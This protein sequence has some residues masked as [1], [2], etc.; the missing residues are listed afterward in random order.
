MVSNTTQ[1]PPPPNQTLIQCRWTLP[2]LN[3][4]GPKLMVWPP[5]PSFMVSASHRKIS[6]F[7]MTTFVNKNK[8]NFSSFSQVLSAE[9]RIIWNV[10]MDTDLS[11]SPT[12][13]KQTKKGTP[14]L[15]EFWISV[16]LCIRE[17]VT[18]LDRMRSETWVRVFF[19]L[20]PSMRRKGMAGPSGLR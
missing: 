6:N 7:N 11:A 19:I 3:L 2:G 20:T 18:Y 8:P 5:L 14:R 15:W 10:S 16:T 17:S 9:D 1:H 4:K 13:K 12:P